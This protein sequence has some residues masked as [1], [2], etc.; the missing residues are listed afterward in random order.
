MYHGYWTQ[1]PIAFYLARYDRSIRCRPNDQS[2]AG[3]DRFR[4]DKRKHR[5]WADRVQ[6]HTLCGSSGRPAA[7]ASSATAEE[8]ERS[9]FRRRI[10]LGLHAVAISQRCGAPGHSAG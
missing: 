4:K 5:G 1:T 3:F 6:R 9:A 2:R 7:V 10:R 8:V